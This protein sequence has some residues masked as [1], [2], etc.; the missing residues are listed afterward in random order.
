MNLK[1]MKELNLPTRCPV[2]NSPVE[3][4]QQ[5]PVDIVNDMRSF[6][7]VITCSNHKCEWEEEHHEYGD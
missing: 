2:C 7:L 4:Y 6:P 3:L 5:S 1:Q